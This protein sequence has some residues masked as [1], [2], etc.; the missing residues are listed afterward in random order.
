MGIRI[1]PKKVRGQFFIIYEL[2]GC[3]KAVD[4]LTE[5]YGIKRMKIILDG[6]KVGNGFDAWYFRNRACFKKRGLRKQTVLHELYHHLVDS[7]KLEILERI[8]EKQANNY[9]AEFLR[10]TKNH[11][12]K[13]YNSFFV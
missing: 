1:P 10:I 13:Q 11:H 7:K 9:V 5:Y 6:R 3:Q 8:E 4:F 12:S 2:K